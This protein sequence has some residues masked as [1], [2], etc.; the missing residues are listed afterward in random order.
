MYSCLFVETKYGQL[1][2]MNDIKGTHENCGSMRCAAKVLKF[3]MV[4]PVAWTL[5]K[6]SMYKKYEKGCTLAKEERR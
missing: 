4:F 3:A 6:Y 1:G 5:L 2:Q